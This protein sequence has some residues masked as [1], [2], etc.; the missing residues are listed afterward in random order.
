MAD[1]STSKPIC[2]LSLAAA[3]LTASRRVLAYPRTFARAL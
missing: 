1:G 2:N 3:Q